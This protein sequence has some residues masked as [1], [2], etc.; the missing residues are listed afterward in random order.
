MSTIQA[1]LRAVPSLLDGDEVPP[2][3]TVEEVNRLTRAYQ[4]WFDGKPNIVRAR[5]WAVFLLLRYTGCRVSEALSIDDTRDLDFRRSE[6]VLPTLKRR[7]QAKRTVPL[8]GNVVAEI[9]RILAT[10]PKL[11]GNLF[12]IHRTTVFLTFRKRA[13][14]A[15]IPPELR[16]PHVLRHT[17]AVE[18]LRAGV[19]VSAVQQILGHAN[20]STTAVYLRF[21]GV[22]IKRIMQDRGLI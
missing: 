11:R 16:H 7:K 5:H 4:E 3:L 19:P 15:G 17:R 13:E 14:E 1:V 20:I 2:H 9:G 12:R 22:E 18:L 6:V 21:S 8:S 10:W